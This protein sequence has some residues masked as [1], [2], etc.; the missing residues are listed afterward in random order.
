MTT[1]TIREH[2]GLWIAA[3][4][5]LIRVTDDQWIVPSQS[6]TGVAYQ[7]DYKQGTCTCPDNNNGVGP[8]CKHLYA[9]SCAIKRE[10]GRVVP[11]PDP[12]TPP[13]KERPTY[14]QNW[15]A[16]NG[17][18]RTEKRRVQA[19]LQDLCSGLPA[20]SRPTGRG[21]LP[22]PSS[23]AVFA[24]AFKV[25]STVST[26][27]FQTDLEDAHGKGH[28]SRHIHYNSVSEYLR[29]PEITPMLHTLIRESCK[30]VRELETEF[31][32]DSTGFDTSRR[33]HWY[34]QKHGVK[35]WVHDWVKVHLAIGVKTNI[36]TAVRID[37]QNA[38]D[39]PQF[40]PLLEATAT[41][42]KIKEV[43]A[44]K[45][46]LSAENVEAVLHA[47]GTPYILFKENTT[48]GVGG[49]FERMFH[50]YCLHK[51]KFL[52]HYHKRS[53]IEATIAGVKKL[54][55]DYV[56]SRTDTA[57]KNEALCKVLCYNLT[58]L[59]HSQCEL[60]ID[61]SFWADIDL[62]GRETPS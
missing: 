37:H 19:L 45:A 34:D 32:I 25:Y 60:G 2:R 14:K 28:V 15:P 8:K 42:F 56:R 55:G 49:L 5:K 57:M 26:R 21:R 1:M 20:F 33:S 62:P 31:A 10:S 29:N 22:V 23:D 44:D 7:V 48:G 24:C 13:P 6:D 53:N 39:S 16:Y 3:T 38:G 50:F 9:V 40:K 36:I 46:Y 35:R 27:R 51:E 43:S 12:H 54:F 61:P 17:A 30:P 59:I 47:G 58:C 41:D 52:E 18:Q 11:L 4:C